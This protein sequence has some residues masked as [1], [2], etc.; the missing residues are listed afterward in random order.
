VAGRPPDFLQEANRWSPPK[1][2]LQLFLRS[3]SRCRPIVLS[4]QAWGSVRMNLKL[5]VVIL[6]IAAM[7]MCAKAQ[8]SNNTTVTH[9]QNAFK[10]ISGD[11]AKTRIYCDM[12]KIFDQIERAGG[13]DTKNSDALYRKMNDLAKKL[14]PDYAALV[15]GLPKVD[16]NSQDA[17]EINATFATLDK[18]CAQ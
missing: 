18:L 10:I 14:G 17:Q 3:Q 9:A 7:P 8:T 5:I 11:K 6:V 16:P 13:K 15:Y 2:R 1:R 4:A 12:A